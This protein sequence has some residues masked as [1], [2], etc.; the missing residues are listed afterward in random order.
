[1][2]ENPFEF[3]KAVEDE[4]FTDRIEDTKRLEANLTHGINTILISPRRW[5]KTSLVKK[6]ISQSKRKDIKFIFVDVFSCKSEYEFCKV[7]ATEVICQT[8]SKLEEWIKLAK[9]FLSNITPKF[10]FGTDPLNDFSLSFAWNPQDNPEKEILQLPE[11]IA[12]KKNIQIVVCFDEFQQIADFKDSLTFQKKLRTIWQHQQHTTYCMFGSKKHL[13]TRLFHSSEC[14]FYKFGDIILLDKIA[15]KEWV[16][17]ICD[18]FRKTGK[19]IEEKQAMEICERA[20]NLSSLVQHL[21]WLVWYKACPDVTDGMIA[22]A[23]D[24]LLDQN[25][26]FYQR[27]LET[28]TVYQKNFL[29]AVANGVNV[30]L[31]RR[32]VLNEYHLESSANVQ[33]VKKAL[34]ARDFIDVDGERVSFNDPFFKLWIMRNITLL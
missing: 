24:E 1:M 32:E 28:M 3:G 31:T 17:F 2:V 26:L 4:Y 27:D 7:L 29:V 16:S 25:R 18:K 20:E 13:M 10:S 21:S 8:S 5:G 19:H 33:A 23:V 12:E 34:V 6:V 14:P 15:E 9:N 30:G 11:K 22:Q